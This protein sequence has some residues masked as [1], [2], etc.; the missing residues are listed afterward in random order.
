MV[1]PLETEIDI[2][3]GQF[4]D[5]ETAEEEIDLLYNVINAVHY[6]QSNINEFKDNLERR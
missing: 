3:R 5:D 4:M 1:D 6:L 2:V